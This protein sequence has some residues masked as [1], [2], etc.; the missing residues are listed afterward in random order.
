MVTTSAAAETSLAAWA[1]A[2][3]TA[4]AALAAGRP[5]EAAAA[6][7]SA[8]LALPA[9]EP[10]ARA[11][12][13]EALAVRGD[14]QPA[15]A[16]RLAAEALPSLP[17]S[18]HGAVLARRAEALLA[19]GHP[20]DAAE[21]WSGAAFLATGP[22]R[23]RLAAAEARA[24]LEAGEPS[25]AA[26][27][28]APAAAQGLPD[29]RL[30]LA[31]AWLAT[32]DPRA[33]AALRDLAVERAGEADGE[34][35]ASLL[36]APPSPGALPLDDRVSRA[37]RLLA[38]T[39][40][41]AALAEIDEVER[42]VGATPLV[43]VLRGIAL[44]QLG[45][46]SDAERVAAPVAALPGP[47][48]PAAARFVLARAAARQGRLDEAA[49][50]YRRVAAERPT[51]PGLSATAQS[52]LADDAA[53]LAAWLPYDGGRFAEA[54]P[55]L[56]RFAREHPG[57]RRAPDAR[58]FSAWALVRAGDRTR[59]R[60]ALR[61]LAAQDTG[62]TRTA[63]LYWLGRVETDAARSVAAFRDAVADD[64]ASWY[65]LLASA[66]LAA[67]GEPLPAPPPL[68][69]SPLPEPPRDAT[70]AATLR[71]SV[72]LAGA[73][74]RDES[75]ALLQQLSRGPD[76]RSR[77]SLLA[78]V[79]ELVEEPEVTHRMARD[80]LPPGI[81]ARRWAYPQAHRA[82]LEP[83]ARALGVDPALALAV[84]RR[85]SAFVA[86]A[87]SGAAA[88]GVLQ[89]RPETAGRVSFLLGV[90]APPDLGL[91][92]ENL[93]IG[94]AYLGL[95]AEPFPQV[96][97]AVAAYNAGP[98][99]AARWTRELAGAPVDEWV[100]N[101]PFRE[102]RAYVRA[103][104]ADWARYRALR[105]EPPPPVDPDAPILAPRPGVSF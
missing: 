2:I 60:D 62:W 103:V 75:S 7:R 61:D 84:M 85:E 63:A 104:M 66:R 6:A 82:V 56:R 39:R 90:V 55:L 20:A 44:L 10:G 96:P 59:A 50:L 86:T 35:A 58:W 47:G 1:E 30:A 81:R 105:G 38:T 65:A 70:L 54:V 91:P 87:R 28:S 74:L 57:A 23:A 16:A 33:Q 40:T 48:E 24:W 52:D 4:S 64:P 25:R 101:V 19:A 11:R 76:V 14:G 68:P 73:G 88:E 34:E 83:A 53:F 77:A 92:A 29:A 80:Y 8:R 12:L 17:V 79:A 89:L 41:R 94:L 69:P 95:L 67:A 36:P 98:V 49:A 13:L 93:R 31:R 72:E 51:V 100:E 102:T 26:R 15:E 42:Q 43:A 3:G 97:A 99:A 45:R 37:R 9:G 5:G 32:G 21:A 18:L 46:P 78:E 71:L 22:D 27:V